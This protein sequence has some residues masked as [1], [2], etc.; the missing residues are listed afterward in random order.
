MIGRK[1]RGTGA[2]PSATLSGDLLT[3]WAGN[4]YGA[5]GFGNGNSGIII[6]ATENFTDAAQGT[7]M[8]FQTVPNGAN[9]PLSRM[10]IK[11]NGSI[12][13]GTQ[14]PSAG[15]EVS[16][17]DNTL[18]NGTIFATSYASGGTSLF[19][20]RRARG[21]GAAPTAVVSGDTLAGFL[22][23]GHTGSGFSGTR[24]GMFVSAAE[25]W[26]ATAQ[27]TNVFFNT[28]GTGTTTP[29]TK[30]VIDPNG[31]VGFGTFFPQAQLEVMRTGTDA[32]FAATVYTNGDGNANPV[33]FTRF[34][35]GTSAAPTAVQSGN[36][37]GL[38]A[39]SGYG[40][41]QFG[42]F[43]GGMGVLAQEDYTDAAQGSLTG[44][45]STAIGS[46]QGQLH[47]AILPSGFVGIGDWN[48]PGLPPTAADRL[49]VFG[50]VRVGTTATNGC[51]KNFAGTGII[52]TCVSDRRFK[53]DITPFKPVLDHLTAL[54]PVHYYW[55]RTEF[56][57]RHFGAAQTYGL[58]AQDVEQVLPEL[59]VTNDDGYKAVDY[60][61]LPLLTIQAVKEL[62]S[63]NDALKQRVADLEKMVRELFATAA[64]R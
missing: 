50:D 38:W 30:M 46:N 43:T 53:K 45:F 39:A 15:L 31:D 11:P 24:G 20:G 16:N 1:A 42:N 41:T 51:V 64:G 57:D 35:N 19:V 62:K 23:Q 44:L 54:Q 21:T 29:S 33:Y 40:A 8:G 55:R 59:V 58:I 26:T 36:I 63:E 7:L 6:Q 37:T 13:M 12:G 3:M 34:A 27:G 22:S 52:G 48:V 28:T 17:A 32:A 14:S 18:G 5:T 2:A 25:N 47:M 49:Q 4:G 10:G 60:S 56:P 9:V 61:K